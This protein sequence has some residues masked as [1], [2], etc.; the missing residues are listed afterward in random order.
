MTTGKLMCIAKRVTPSD[1][2]RELSPI[3]AFPLSSTGLKLRAQNV[4]TASYPAAADSCFKCQNLDRPL[5]ATWPVPN[6][7]SC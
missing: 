7:K 6:Y 2:P 5:C 4:L 1:K 3:S